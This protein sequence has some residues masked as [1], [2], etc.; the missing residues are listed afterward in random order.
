MKMEVAEIKKLVTLVAQNDRRAFDTFYHLYY[1]QVFRTAYYYI[2]DVEA[3]REVVSNTFFSVWKSR[4]S[5]GDVENLSSYLYTATRHEAIRYLSQNEQDTLPLSDLTPALEVQ[6]DH[7]PETDLIDSELTT[8]LD[9][10]LQTLP[11]RCRLIFMMSREEGIDNKEIALRLD[12][13]ESTVRVQLKSAVDKIIERLKSV[14]P[15]LTLSLL[16]LH[17]FR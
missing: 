7:S 17:L 16:L 4:K 2:K 13:S 6:S 8:L 11:E 10:I 5:L 3:C 1:K 14:Y 15:H 9:R 12:I